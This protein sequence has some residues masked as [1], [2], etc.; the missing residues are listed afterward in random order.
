MPIDPRIA[1]SIRSPDIPSSLDAY[2]KFAQI[3]GMQQEQ[4][5]NALRMQAA[6]REAE[7][8]NRLAELD[9]SSPEYGQKLYRISPSIGA[10]YEKKQSEIRASQ[11]RETQAKTSTAQTRQQ[12]LSQARRDISNNPSDAQ[13]MA[14]AEDIQNSELFTPEEKAKTLKI[15]Q[16]LLGLP[17]EQRKSWLSQQGASAGE[18]TPK[19]SSKTELARLLEEQ[20]NYAPG[21][22][23][24]NA[25]QT[26]IQKQST[27]APAVK[28]NVGG[29]VLEK[30][31]QKEKGKFNVQSYKDISDLAKVAVKTLP[32]FETQEKIL[33]QGFKTGFGTDAQKVAASMLSALGVADATTYAANAELFSAA[34]NQ[35]VLQKQ[36]EQKGPQTESDARRIEAASSRLSNTPEGNKFIISIAKAQLRRDIEQRNF[37]D[38]WW[39]ENKTYEGAEDAWYSGEGSKSL[40]DR[41]ELKKYAEGKSEQPKQGLSSEDKKALDW[42]NSNPNDPRAS[43]I[44][45]RLGIK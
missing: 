38:K 1:L 26:A 42:A 36:L 44:K 35:A 33:D 32:A 9:P 30:E 3:Q 45:Q 37:Y 19:Q 43:Q 15:Q 31:E 21:S 23:E 7:Q 13:I 8:Q 27:H 25:Y 18:L 11:A 5:M 4:Q 22:P 41:A 6:Q 16:T 40:F 39:R 10:E 14:H 28:V 17:I 2:A 34:A 20:K 29:T 24:F 12:M